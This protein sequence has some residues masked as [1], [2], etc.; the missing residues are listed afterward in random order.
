M[1]KYDLVLKIFSFLV[2]KF[3]FDQ[4]YFSIFLYEYTE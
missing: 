1:K 2:F 3:L 4:S